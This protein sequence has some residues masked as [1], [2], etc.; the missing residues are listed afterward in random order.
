MT[1]PADTTGRAEEFAQRAAGR[2]SGLAGELAAFLLANKKWW[3]LPII[4]AL[5]LL[6]LLIVLN[7]TA[8]APFI[9]TLW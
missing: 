6:G 5:L 2:R 1:D 3:L 9:Y 4:V 7:G 8:L